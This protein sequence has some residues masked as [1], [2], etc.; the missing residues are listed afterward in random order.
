MLD[1]SLY[2]HIIHGVGGW[3]KKIVVN[4]E[5]LVW[6]EEIPLYSLY[7]VFLLHINFQ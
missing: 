6:K 4:R 5:C 1:K 3:E 7:L 2:I